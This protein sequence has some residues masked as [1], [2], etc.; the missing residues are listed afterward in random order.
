MFEVKQIL[1]RV[2]KSVEL[3]HRV[4]SGETRARWETVTLLIVA[5]P[6]EPVEGLPRNPPDIYY[7]SIIALRKYFRRFGITVPIEIIDNEIYSR[8]LLL[9]RSPI[10]QYADVLALWYEVKPQ[11]MRL[12]MDAGLV[13]TTRARFWLRG[14][15]KG[16]FKGLPLVYLW[17]S[18]PHSAKWQREV[19]PQ[20]RSLV[21]PMIKVSVDVNFFLPL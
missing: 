19:L 14:L 2:A 16:K 7:C 10:D 3:V 18:K 8:T 21:E 5:R 6:N 1:H 11:F 4:Q 20:L 15:N 13:R 17:T 12:L 9:V